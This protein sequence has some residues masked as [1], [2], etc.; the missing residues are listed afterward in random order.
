MWK[1]GGTKRNSTDC[2]GHSV[3][4]REIEG[5]PAKLR[6]EL[7]LWQL[8]QMK[9]QTCFCGN[10]IFVWPVYFAK[11]LSSLFWLE[12]NCQRAVNQARKHHTS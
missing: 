11:L 10:P 2:E 6:K 3:G 7:G 1:E 12:C 5:K 4:T 9:T 8:S